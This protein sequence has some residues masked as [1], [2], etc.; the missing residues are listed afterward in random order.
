MNFE[1]MLEKY[2]FTLPTSKKKLFLRPILVKEEKILL[3]KKTDNNENFLKSI[4]QVIENCTLNKDINWHEMSYNDFAFAFVQ[5]RW[6][7]RD[8][9]V[10]IPL[11]CTNEKCKYHKEELIKEFNIKEIIEIN[12]EDKKYSNIFKINENYSIEL[13]EMSFE[14]VLKLSRFEELKN[15]NPFII[16]LDMITDHTKA[17]LTEKEKYKDKNDIKEF[18][19]HLKKKDII[20]IYKWFENE[21]Q[22]KI[23]A[24]WTC[25]ECKTDNVFEEVDVVNFFDIC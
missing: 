2:E 21:P 8:E 13:K 25:D 17:I 10:N 22:I 12:N 18:I 9:L 3:M 11:N 15:E 4:L 23:K 14:F 7:S 5:L 19:E 24:K 20:E 6:I 1:N 16:N